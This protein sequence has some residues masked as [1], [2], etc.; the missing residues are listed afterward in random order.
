MHQVHADH[1]VIKG[2]VCHDPIFS[3]WNARTHFEF[4]FT[5]IYSGLIKRSRRQQFDP[6]PAGTAEPDA[7]QI[8]A[9][10]ARNSSAYDGQSECSRILQQQ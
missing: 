5:R 4:V 7:A 3:F 10:L 8:S 9:G 2:S 6:H 1:G